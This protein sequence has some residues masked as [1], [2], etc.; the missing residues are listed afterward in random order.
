MACQVAA[1]GTALL[2]V[3]EGEARINCLSLAIHFVFQGE[4]HGALVVR[5]N[6]NTALL[7]KNLAH[8]RPSRLGYG[9]SDAKHTAPAARPRC[10]GHHVAPLRQAVGHL[11]L[12][13]THSGLADGLR[14]YGLADAGEQLG[15]CSS[16]AQLAQPLHRRFVGEQTAVHSRFAESPYG[17]RVPAPGLHLLDGQMAQFAPPHHA[18]AFAEEGAVRPLGL[19][20]SHHRVARLCPQRGQCPPTGHQGAGRAAGVIVGRTLCQGLVVVGGEEVERQ[21]GI[22]DRGSSVFHGQSWSW[23]RGLGARTPVRAGSSPSR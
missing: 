3:E 15:R 9:M 2:R 16:A 13:V 10:L 12:A 4:V 11:F 18:Y 17:Q 20:G 22:R 5:F 21:G 14:A 1:I 23:G 6:F 7:T 8:A 19:I